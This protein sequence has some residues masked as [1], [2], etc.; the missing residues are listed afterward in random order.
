MAG[1]ALS[2]GEEGAPGAGQG[3]IDG[4]FCVLRRKIDRLT[5]LDRLTEAKA[6]EMSAYPD[7]WKTPTAT[8]LQLTGGPGVSGNAGYQNLVRPQG[9]K[10]PETSRNRNIELL[11]PRG[12]WGQQVSFGGEKQLILVPLSAEQ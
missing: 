12:A 1:G 4:E 5:V 8:H 2:H 6:R 11:C 7:L 3:D 10:A 9:G